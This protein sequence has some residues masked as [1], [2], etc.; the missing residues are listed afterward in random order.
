[1]I[2]LGVILLIYIL[3][4]YHQSNY[5]IIIFLYKLV[6]HLNFILFVKVILKI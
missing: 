3:K 6:R 5:I 4:T 2:I 1:M